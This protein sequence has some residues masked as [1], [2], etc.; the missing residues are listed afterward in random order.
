[1]PIF[2]FSIVLFFITLCICKD[3]SENTKE[4]QSPK[5]I[6]PEIISTIS[7]EEKTFIQGFCYRKPLFYISSG[8]Y[9]SSSV[10][11][12]DSTGKS[13]LI[14]NMPSI[15]F[16]EGCAIAFDKIYQITWQE[17]CC[18]VYSLSSLSVV[19]TFFYSGEG[20][21]LTFDGKHLI[22]SNGSDTLYYRDKDF[23]TV[24]KVSISYNGNP[25]SQLNELE[26]S[27]GYIYANVW[28]SDYVCEI[29]PATGKAERVINCEE[30]VKMEAP[31]ATEDVLNGIA[32]NEENNLFYITGKNWK[33]IYVI[34][35]PEK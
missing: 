2:R 13:T 4:E 27:N 15:Y 1:M 10:R 35:I 8:L 18:F 3:K 22:M 29:N 17:K 26:Y 5:I 31:D 11:I 9:G 25:L 28:H 21:G 12:V 30:I 34:R 14:V 16:G 32:Y 7:L 6:N 19:D 33:N 23:A 24:K 20:W